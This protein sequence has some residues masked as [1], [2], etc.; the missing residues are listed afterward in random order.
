MRIIFD[1]IAGILQLLLQY[2]G[3]LILSAPAQEVAFVRERQNLRW[4]TL[5]IWTGG[6]NFYILL[7]YIGTLSTLKKILPSNPARGHRNVGRQPLEIY[8]YKDE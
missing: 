2:V 7:H 6:H 8:E 4:N 3:A 5:T 1:N